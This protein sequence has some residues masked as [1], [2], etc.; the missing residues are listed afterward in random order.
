MVRAMR[1]ARS[2]PTVTVRRWLQSGSTASPEVARGYVTGGGSSA[3]VGKPPAAETAA[4]EPKNPRRL[5]RSL[6]MP[7][8]GASSNKEDVNAGSILR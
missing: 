4:T 1:S 3:A 5:S 2:R 6:E 7:L 8:I